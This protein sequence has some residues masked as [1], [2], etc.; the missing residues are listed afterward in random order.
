MIEIH[1]ELAKCRC[2]CGAAVVPPKTAYATDGCKRRVKSRRYCRNIGRDRR[3]AW[4]RKMDRQFEQGRPFALYLRAVEKSIKVGK[5]EREQDVAW[6]LVAKGAV[7][8]ENRDG[9]I[10]DV[11]K[12]IDPSMAGA[13][14]GFAAAVAA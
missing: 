13:V 10:R 5:S 2:G 14:F 11:G 3:A 8:Y 9:Q 6:Q 7:A 12:P 4:Q 1:D